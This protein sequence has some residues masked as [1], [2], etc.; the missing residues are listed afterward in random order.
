MCYALL[1]G[2]DP[3]VATVLALSTGFALHLPLNGIWRLRRRL[4]SVSAL[5][6]TPRLLASG[7]G[8]AMVSAEGIDQTYF[9]GDAGHFIGNALTVDDEGMVLRSERLGRPRRPGDELPLGCPVPPE[10]W[11]ETLAERG[12][13]SLQYGRDA[14]DR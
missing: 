9:G 5:R 4:L 10:A 8:R 11:T 13:R 1:R 14:R 3:S 2:G 6:D 12:P 7:Y